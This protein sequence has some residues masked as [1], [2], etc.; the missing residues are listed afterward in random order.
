MSAYVIG[1]VEVT[2]PEYRPLIAIRE[3]AA[4]THLLIAEGT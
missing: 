2:D 1:D 3:R 4:R